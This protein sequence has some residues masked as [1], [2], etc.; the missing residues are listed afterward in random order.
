MEGK[1]RNEL[2][3]SLY[4]VLI[5]VIMKEFNSFDFQTFFNCSDVWVDME[6]TP[7]LK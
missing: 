5:P 2:K 7:Q 6:N 3:I 4:F 1:V